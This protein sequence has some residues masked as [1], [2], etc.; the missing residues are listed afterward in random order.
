MNKSESKYFNTA[1]KMDEALMTLLE[2]KDFQYITIKELCDAAGVNRS[3]FYLHYESMV[4]LLEETLRYL[5]G[6]FNTYFETNE[7]E[8]MDKV[9][10]GSLDSLIFI[11]KEHLEPYLKFIIEH[12]KIFIATINKPDVFASENSFKYLSE[13]LFFP[14]MKRF[15]IPE[16]EQEYILMFYIKGIMGILQHWIENQCQETVEFI[17]DLII[18]IIISNF[19]AKEYMRLNHETFDIEI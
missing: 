4:D 10:N 13:K 19:E 6:K 14:V 15:H 2:K 9:E 7:R 3:T 18:K 17:T 11:T 8:I 12:K 1:V 16:K 5:N